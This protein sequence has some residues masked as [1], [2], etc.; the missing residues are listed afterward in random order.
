VIALGD[1]RHRRIEPALEMRLA[2]QGGME[3]AFSAAFAAHQGL[4]LIYL[5]SGKGIH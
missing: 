4:G 5:Q 1:V 2:R 3:L